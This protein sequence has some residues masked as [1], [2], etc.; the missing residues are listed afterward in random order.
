MAAG[1]TAI[2]AVILAGGKGE[3]LGGVNKALLEIGGERLIDRACR[4]LRGLRSRAAGGRR[5]LASRSTGYARSPTLPRDYAG[6]LAGVAAAVAA[7]DDDP[8]CNGCSAS[9]STP[10]SSRAIFSRALY[11]SLADA[12]VVHRLLRRTGLSDQCALAARGDPQPARRPCATA[13]RRTASSASPRACEPSASTMPATLA[14]DPFANAN[15]PEDL[16]NLRLARPSADS[17]GELPLG[18]GNQ[19]LYTGAAFGP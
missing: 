2:A 8:S 4:V 16:D 15:T 10:R 12:D 3:R 9:R 19:I 1:V 13:P 18:K 17:R 11:R 6:P 5:Q 7:L 14:D